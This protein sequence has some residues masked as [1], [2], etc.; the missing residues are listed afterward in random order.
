MRRREEFL[1]TRDRRAETLKGT[2]KLLTLPAG[3]RARHVE[4]AIQ[5]GRIVNNAVSGDVTTTPT[6]AGFEEDALF[7]VEL[8]VEFTAAIQELSTA[9]EEVR[10]VAL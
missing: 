6:H 8:P 1:K 2:Y 7:R 3:D 9:S 10:M 5:T 4:E